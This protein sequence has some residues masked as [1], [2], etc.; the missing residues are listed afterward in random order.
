MATVDP[1][2]H[3]RMSA[4]ADRFAAAVL[5]GDIDTLGTLFTPG[6]E[7]HQWAVSKVLAPE[8]SA[9][10][11]R[12]LTRKLPDLHFEQRRPTVTEDG[13]VDRYVLCG[14]T[15]DGIAVASPTCLVVTVG[16]DGLIQLI[17]EYFD[18]VATQAISG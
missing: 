3:A 12:W 9:R 4:L 8:Q 11:A 15:A 16:G 1:D 7:I 17:D 10:V 5:A 13:Y 6:A 2:H 14:T 18:T